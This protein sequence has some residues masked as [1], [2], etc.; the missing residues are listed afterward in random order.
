M[1]DAAAIAG[2][3]VN[4]LPKRLDD[5]PF[6]A[7]LL[8][9]DR[10]RADALS[11]L[12]SGLA[13]PR[14]RVVRM[15]SS[16][17]SRLTL[18]RVMLQ[19]TGQEGS[20]FLADNARR[21]ARTIAE[22]HRHE[23]SVVLLITQAETLHSKTLRLLQAMAPY[24]AEHGAPT[25]Q[26]V[27]VGRPAFRSLL[28]GRGMTPLREAL[29]LPA[30]IEFSQSSSD[31]TPSAS[32][33]VNGQPERPEPAPATPPAPFLEPGGAAS[34]SV[35]VPDTR[36]RSI[37]VRWLLLLAI[38]LL[39]SAVAILRIR[40]VSDWGVPTQSAPVAVL[41]AEPQPRLEAD[42]AA[43][44]SPVAPASDPSVP[45][46]AATASPVPD[47]KPALPGRVVPSITVAPALPP[48]LLRQFR[49]NTA[50]LATPDPRIVIHVPAGSEGAAA[51][52]AHLLASL[53]PRPGTVEARRV[54]DTPNR[55]TI[56]YFHP[57]D[58]SAA[59]QVAAWMA[60]TGLPWTLRDFSTFQPRPSRGTIEVWLPRQ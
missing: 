46:M 56:R 33:A 58:E 24:F 22:R 32:S 1:P 30:S 49:G 48:D 44:P 16:V 59:R 20:A 45:P 51:L 14:V 10:Q 29:G 6:T 2:M 23:T 40:G 37:L 4:W 54:P 7:L 57:E 3:R 18:E 55:P 31:D 17:R 53:S 52:S 47:L 41:P 13:K 39:A 35:S 19:A 26:V 15:G 60:D 9:D 5:R 34:A 36:R 28:D 21:I 27:F 50:T 38:V 12:L 11:T 25:L 8:E 42:P 43:S